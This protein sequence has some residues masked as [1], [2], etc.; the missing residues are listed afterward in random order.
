MKIGKFYLEK[1]L[2]LCLII[3]GIISCLSI[4]SATKLLSSYY[5]TLVIKQIIWYIIGF[6]AVFFILYIGND[7]IFDGIWYLYGIG[8]LCLIGLL[9]FAPEVNDAKCWFFIPGIGGIHTMIIFQE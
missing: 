4:Y 1:N 2:L 3:F 8:I 7:K 6:L 9:L 5:S